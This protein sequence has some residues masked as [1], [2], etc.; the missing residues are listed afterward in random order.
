VLVNGDKRI[1]RRTKMIL[2]R[3]GYGVAAVSSYQDATELLDALTPDLV[4]ADI[5]LDAFN[6]LQLAIRSRLA[7]P[8][9]PVIVTHNQ[10]DPTLEAEAQRHGVD[11]LVAMPEH[12]ELLRRIELALHERNWQQR[13]VR[14]WSRKRVQGE[15]QVTVADAPARVIDMSY[16]GVKLA[17]S[18]EADIPVRFEIRLPSS[19]TPVWAHRVWT[20]HASEDQLCGAELDEGATHWRDFVNS[21]EAGPV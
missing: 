15:V 6:G 5:R 20:A 8:H 4:V 7:H 14:R 12:P 10:P 17:F 11:F 21:V 2:A 16:G 19:E 18:D 13:R 9:V 1:L 3:E